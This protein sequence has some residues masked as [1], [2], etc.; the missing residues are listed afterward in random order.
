MNFTDTAD[1]LN[2]HPET[3][4]LWV[5]NATLQTQ[6]LRLA[7]EG[8]EYVLTYPKW[9]IEAVFSRNEFES[10]E[11]FEETELNFCVRVSENELT[12]AAIISEEVHSLLAASEQIPR[13]EDVYVEVVVRGVHDALW[14]HLERVENVPIIEQPHSDWNLLPSTV[15]SDDLGLT[16]LA[17]KPSNRNNLLKQLQTETEL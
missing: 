14:S 9:D 4:R 17:P 13:T 12:R 11:F 2:C 3:V 16:R 7:K 6:H 1:V 5:Y 15:S 10:A 8:E